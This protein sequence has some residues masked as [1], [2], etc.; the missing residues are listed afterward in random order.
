[1]RV[2]QL[3]PSLA[4][5]FQFSTGAAA[6]TAK[7]LWSAATGRSPP[8]F[9]LLA[10]R[11]LSSH[12]H[13]RRDK[14]RPLP[15]SVRLPPAWAF[16]GLPLAPFPFF[17]LFLN[18]DFNDERAFAPTA[19]ASNNLGSPTLVLDNTPFLFLFFFFSIPPSSS[20]TDARH[21]R[22]PIYSLLA[23]GFSHVAC[24]LSGHRG[25]YT[26]RSD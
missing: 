23:S 21:H 19:F 2:G 17:F 22:F 15:P 18:F 9:C 16:A 25:F 10:S 11:H 24:C 8:T 6:A 7:G 12:P 20:D 13:F 4:S 14:R 26:A 5:S 1:V 3:P